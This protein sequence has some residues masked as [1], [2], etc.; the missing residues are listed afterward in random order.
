[1][2][3]GRVYRL[4]MAVIGAAC[5]IAGVAIGLTIP[6][7][8]DITSSGSDETSRLGRT[9]SRSP[10][11]NVY[12]P[13][14]RHD[15]YVRQKQLELAEMLEQHCRVTGENCELAKASREALARD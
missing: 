10:G 2:V 5:L 9:T 14:I 12:S 4:R 6:R 11:R 8:F 3:T 13:D 7:A 15:E 1:M